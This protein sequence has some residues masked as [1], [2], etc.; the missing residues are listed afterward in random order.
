MKIEGFDL[1]NN[2]EKS[3]FAA[4]HSR[5][6]PHAVIIEGGS[7]EERMQLAKKISAALICS[8]GGTVP[9]GSC[10]ACIKA[11]A[12]SHADILV[13]SV[14]DKPRAFKVDFVREIRA[15]AY[16]VP[17]EADRKVFILENSHTMGVEGQNAILKILEEPPPYINFILLCSSKSGFLP[18]VLSRATVFALG[19]A[20]TAEDE[21]LPPEEIVAAAKGVALAVTALDDIEIIKAAAVFEK[22]QKLLRAALPMIQEIFA[23]ALRIKYSAEEEGSEFGSVP[24]EI[25][26]KLS[27]RAF[28]A[29][30]ECTDSLMN[31]I[32][33]NANHNLMVTAVCTKMRSAATIN[34][35]G[36]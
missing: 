30:I 3:I 11:A 22:N 17:N 27:R 36:G 15:K 9:C 12:D 24:A 21:S 26:P 33:L 34:T 19:Q 32:K 23:Q 8:S 28:L 31:S 7:P 10:P 5:R 20:S 6:F 18:T 13:Y 4:M 35:Y 1:T 16:I 14:E 29:L 2:V 25:A